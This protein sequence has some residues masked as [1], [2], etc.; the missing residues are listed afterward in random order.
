MTFRTP[1][2][3]QARQQR[4]EYNELQRL[5]TL[6]VLERW[7]HQEAASYGIDRVYIF[8]SVIRPYAFHT[9]SDVDLA[10]APLSPDRF[11][12]AI[13]AISETVEREVDL[14][15]LFKYPAKQHFYQRICQQANVWSKL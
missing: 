15:E 4:R 8:G 9:E 1:L 11:F 3:D 14:I 12:A 13:G 7:L 2:V 6:V 10:I 5:S